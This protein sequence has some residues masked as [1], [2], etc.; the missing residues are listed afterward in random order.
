MGKNF[1][2]LM[3]INGYIVT[4]GKWGTTRSLQDDGKPCVTRV[5]RILF[6]IQFR[7]TM[8]KHASNNPVTF[9]TYVFCCPPLQEFLFFQLSFCVYSL[10][11]WVEERVTGKLFQILGKLPIYVWWFISYLDMVMYDNFYSLRSK[12]FR[13]S[14]SRK[15]EREQKKEWRERGRGKD[16]KAY[17]QFLA[18]VGVNHLPPKILASC[19]NFYETVEKKRGL[20]D[21]VLAYEGG[22][23]L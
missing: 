2:L 11:C 1:T 5:T 4:V 9:V 14:S 20:Y 18:G 23:I 17:R 19:L 8:T 22:S 15:L 3:C 21:T 7:R 16:A 13:A 12:R 6:E 10:V